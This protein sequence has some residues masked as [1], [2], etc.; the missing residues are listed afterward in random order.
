MACTCV[1]M[2][3][4]KWFFFHYRSDTAQESARR[5][6]YMA[7]FLGPVL[8]EEPSCAQLDG[9]SIVYNQCQCLQLGLIT[10]Q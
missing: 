7:E 5:L 9:V 2:Q 1:C 10:P 3:V 4:L 8:E 6:L